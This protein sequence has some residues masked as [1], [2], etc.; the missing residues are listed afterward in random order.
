M[1]ST[2]TVALHFR[3]GVPFFTYLGSK[4]KHAQLAGKSGYSKSLTVFLDNSFICTFIFQEN[5][6]RRH[7][8]FTKLPKRN[9][10]W[11]TQMELLVSGSI[12]IY[13][14]NNVTQ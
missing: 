10:R 7:P 3:K 4:M 5:S 2:L 14:V 12:E 9:A 11:R 8:S 13:E 6:A 1:Y